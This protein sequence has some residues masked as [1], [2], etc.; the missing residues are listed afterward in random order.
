MIQP[1]ALVFLLEKKKKKAVGAEGAGV[2][3]WLSGDA[4]PHRPALAAQV[5]GTAGPAPSRGSA[6][7]APGARAAPE[8][9]ADPAGRGLAFVCFYSLYF[10]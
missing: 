2:S 7:A 10:L 9:A 8:K 4:G 5:S 3:P 1:R 6:P